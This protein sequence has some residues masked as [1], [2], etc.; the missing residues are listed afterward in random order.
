MNYDDWGE[1]P[2]P[3][4]DSESEEYWTMAR[5]GDLAVQV[6]AECGERQLYPRELCRHCWSRDLSLEPSGGRGS[7]YSYT[8][9]HI[10]GQPGYDEETPYPVALVE[11]DLPEDNPSGR[12]VRLTSHVV[13]CEEADLELGMPLEVEF[14]HVSDDPDVDLPV[15]APAGSEP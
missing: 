6:C 8:R 15:F 10:S 5:E 13:A 4:V 12:P 1:K 7:L 9:C 11:L 2:V 14:R 3:M